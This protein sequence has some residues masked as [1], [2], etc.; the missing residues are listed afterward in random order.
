MRKVL[1][2][3]ALLLC[4]PAIGDSQSINYYPAGGAPTTTGGSSFFAGGVSL[5]NTITSPYANL[6][7]DDVDTL[8]LRNGTNAQNFLV[9]NTYTSASAYE[10]GYIGWSGNT[11]ILGTASAGGG[12]A[13][14]LEFRTPSQI[15]AFANAS[16][17]K[18]FNVENNNKAAYPDTSDDFSIGFSTKLISNGYF[19]RSIQGSKT[20]ALTEG[21]ATTV[22]TVAV[23]QTAGSNFAAGE[24]LYTVYAT[25]GTDTQTLNGSAFFSAV[26]KA[27]TEACQITDDQIGTEAAS[28][29]TLVCTVACAVG[30]TDVVGITFDCTSS[31]TQSTL[32]ALVRFDMQKTNTLTFP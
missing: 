2:G 26:N 11:F 8:A 22:A 19:A 10:R 16:G 7:G 21:A 14:N 24:V 31:L 6:F 27:G 25:D 9:Y 32:N 29:G 17:T 12:S 15:F 20:K 28:T 1:V 30:L 3:L 4:L 23:P 5:G 18:F 13:R